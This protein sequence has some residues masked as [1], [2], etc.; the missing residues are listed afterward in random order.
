EVGGRLGQLGAQVAVDDRL[1]AATVADPRL[2]VRLEELDQG[3]PAV[4]ASAVAEDERALVGLPLGLEL[5]VEV[6]DAAQLDEL[7][8]RLRAR[9]GALAAAE[10][11]DRASASTRSIIS[12]I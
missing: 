7:V 8:A 11:H 9:P 5:G 4:Q 6:A 1:Q 12:L 3:E 2:L 10:A